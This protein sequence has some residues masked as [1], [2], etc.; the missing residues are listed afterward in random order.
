MF[1]FNHAGLLLVQA[2][3]YLFYLKLVSKTH[4]KKKNLLD[5]F[6]VDLEQQRDTMIRYNKDRY[7]GVKSKSRK[8]DG[9]GGFVYLI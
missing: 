9:G 6:A 8:K 4:I 7:Y 5:S 3:R 2:R 1:L